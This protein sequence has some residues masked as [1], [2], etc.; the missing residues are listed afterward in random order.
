MR[1][2]LLCNALILGLI[3]QISTTQEALHISFENMTTPKSASIDPDANPKDQNTSKRA[4]TDLPPKTQLTIN[5]VSLLDN[6]STQLLRLLATNP[7]ETVLEIAFPAEQDSPITQEIET[8]QTLLVLFKQ[9]KKIYNTESPLLTVHDVAPGVWFPG[10]NAPY[11]LKGQE[12]FILSA[13]RKCNLLTFL[14]T[15]LGCFDY[16]FSFLNESFLDVFCPSSSD[17]SFDNMSPTILGGKLLKTQA[18]LYLDLKTQ[19]YISAVETLEGLQE[20]QEPDASPSKQEILDDIFPVKLDSYLIAKRGAFNT[21][22]TPSEEDFIARCA[23]RRAKLSET[24]NLQQ[25][26]SNYEWMEFFK[27]LFEYVSKNI[28]FLIWGRKGRGKSPL[29]FDLNDDQV[30]EMQKNHQKSQQLEE[31]ALKNAEEEGSETTVNT[32]AKRPASEVDIMKVKKIKRTTPPV[33]NSSDASAKKPKQK[34]L[35]TKEEE[36]ALIAAL[37]DHGPSWSKILELHGAGGSVSEA[38]KNRSQV[39]LKD[40]ARNWKMFFLKSGLPVPDYLSKVTGDLERDEK[41]KKRS[42][43][44]KRNTGKSST[45]VDLSRLDMTEPDV[46]EAVQKNVEII[47]M[48]VPEDLVQVSS[49]VDPQLNQDE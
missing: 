48:N 26:G 38:L 49:T 5:S 1:K 45:N 4:F 47:D 22:L 41:F 2:I 6:V 23:H 15:I 7:P 17:F 8:F 12:T 42:K 33:V 27:E 9:V 46:Q 29:Y 31:Q 37:K 19:A 36:E 3:S 10:E 32:S 40:K 20:Q 21:H 18:V 35:W 28:G 24:T 34:R 14:L 25:L 30:S 39:Q 13:I 43:A 16:G 44:K 11:I